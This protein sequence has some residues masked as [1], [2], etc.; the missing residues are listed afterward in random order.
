MVEYNTNLSYLTYFGEE[1]YASEFKQGRDTIEETHQQ[2]PVQGRCVT[3]FGQIGSRVQADC[4]QCEHCGN[5]QTDP[6]AG[7]FSMDPE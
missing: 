4:G 6:I 1:M 7:R 5:S 2:E 3:N